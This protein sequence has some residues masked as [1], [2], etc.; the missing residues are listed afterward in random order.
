MVIIIGLF[1]LAAPAKIH[2][3]R[4]PLLANSVD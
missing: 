2:K 4:I 3:L 1:F